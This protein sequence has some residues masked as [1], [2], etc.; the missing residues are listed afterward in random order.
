MDFDLCVQTL[1]LLFRTTVSHEHA[2][3]ESST[4]QQYSKAWWRDHILYYD[5]SCCQYIAPSKIRGRRPLRK[6]LKL[7]VCSP[8]ALPIMI[9]NLSNMLPYSYHWENLCSVQSD[10]TENCFFFKTQ[11]QVQGCKRVYWV[12]W[13]ILLEGC[14]YDSFHRA[15]P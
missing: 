6:I 5:K 9:S 11:L 10:Q 4:S 14:F 15:I 3:E 2:F 1:Q 7:H 8:S 13:L 12:L